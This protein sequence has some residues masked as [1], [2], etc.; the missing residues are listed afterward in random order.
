MSSKTPSG[1][2]KAQILLNIHLLPAILSIVLVDTPGLQLCPST[3]CSLWAEKDRVAPTPAGL[4]DSTGDL[5]ET[6]REQGIAPS[7]T[8]VHRGLLEVAGRRCWC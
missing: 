8:G 4:G 3:A 2:F 7:R 1:K 5:Q 6:Q